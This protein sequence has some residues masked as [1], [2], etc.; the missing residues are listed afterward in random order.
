MVVTRSKTKSK[1]SKPKK[2][3]TIRKRYVPEMYSGELSGVV[4]VEQS[5][6]IEIPSKWEAPEMVGTPEPTI[7]SGR[8]KHVGKI[9]NVGRGNAAGIEFIQFGEPIGDYDIQYHFSQ[10]QNQQHVGVP[11]ANIPFFDKGYDLPF[12]SPP[13]GIRNLLKRVKASSK[14]KK[15]RRD[16]A[17]KHQ[18]MIDSEVD[19]RYWTK[20]GMY[21][22]D[23]NIY[24]DIE[25]KNALV[26]LYD[27][28]RRQSVNQ[29]SPSL[30]KHKQGIQS[31]NKNI[32]SKLNPD[33]LRVLT[34]QDPRVK[35]VNTPR[36]MEAIISGQ[37]SRYM[38]DV[39]YVKYG[40]T[41]IPV[42]KP[43]R[44]RVSDSH[45]LS[46]FINN[47]RLV[48]ITPTRKIQTKKKTVKKVPSN[49]K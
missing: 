48:K 13:S 36:G 32:F 43:K 10:P 19:E 3:R 49:R 33:A 38:S 8:G 7:S 25:R 29:A 4:G 37:S 31:K 27:Y 2:T 1:R 9:G 45:P 15:D 46:W 44:N 40:D 30:Y 6:S 39:N 22:L 12:D 5:D 18:L 17:Y 16:F 21:Y 47:E 11:A 26:A 14:Y 34:G 23:V 35:I 41:K 24:D 20:D 42:R 28:R